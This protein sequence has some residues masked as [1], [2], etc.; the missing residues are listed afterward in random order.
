MSIKLKALKR[1]LSDKLDKYKA[2][3]AV[4][5][6]KNV[7]NQNL[8]LDKVEFDKVYEEAGESNLIDL[9]FG[10]LKSKVI[11]KDIAYHPVKHTPIH[12]DLYQVNMKE[13]ITTTI[14]LEFIGESKAVKELGGLLMKYVDEVEVQCLPGDLVDHIDV[15]ISRLV[16]FEESIYMADLNIPESMELMHEDDEIVVN[17]ISPKDESEVKEEVTEESKEGE[18]EK[19]EEGEKKEEEKKSEEK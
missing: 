13:K 16:S 9:E 11:I 1:D 14:P 6:G 4:L 5:Y 7:D 15:D 12:V 3:P 19:K 2:I 18:E 17:V 8:T 10:D